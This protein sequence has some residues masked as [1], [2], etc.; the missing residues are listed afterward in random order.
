MQACTALSS[1]GSHTPRESVSSS[2]IFRLVQYALDT[3][4]FFDAY[5]AMTTAPKKS[6]KAHMAI[7]CKEAAPF[8]SV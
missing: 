6:A 8:L 1:Y 2:Y 4:L 7:P 5:N 3:A